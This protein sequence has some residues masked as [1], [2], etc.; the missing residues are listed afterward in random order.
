[1]P[2]RIIQFSQL[3]NFGRFGNQIFQYVFARAYA[4]KY[5]AILELPTWIGE[6]IFKDVSHTPISCRLPRIPIDHIP[7]GRVNIDLF[8]YFQTKECFDILSEKKIRKWLVFQDQFN[9]YLKQSNEIIAHQRMGD[10]VTLWPDIFCVITKKSFLNSCIKFRICK[11]NLIYLS[12]ENPTNNKMLNDIAYSK[13]SNS[14]Y[15]SGIYEDKGISFLPD[16][17]RMIN[18][19]ILFRSNS[20]FSFWAGFFKNENVYSP[21]VKGKTGYQDVE[22]VK[23]NR[24]A[25]C[26][27]TDDIIFGA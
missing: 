15:G 17:F 13:I 24:S 5:D 1:M 27:V 4:E 18:S 16:F 9:D 10:Y 19:K 26:S 12:E 7:W 11:Q 25:I 6:K 22:F 20:S 3:G 14:R 23:D 2:K 21:I 8:G